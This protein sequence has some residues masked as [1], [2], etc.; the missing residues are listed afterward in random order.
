LQLLFLPVVPPGGSHL[1]PIK[2]SRFSAKEDFAVLRQ[3]LEKSL[4]LLVY[5]ERQHG[6]VLTTLRGPLKIQ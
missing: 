2:I 3:V 4:Y 5:L 6:P 1:T